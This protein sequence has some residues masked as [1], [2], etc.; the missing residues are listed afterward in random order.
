[1]INEDS[2]SVHSQEEPAQAD[3]SGSEIEDGT[4]NNRY[5]EVDNTSKEVSLIFERNAAKKQQKTLEG[6]KKRH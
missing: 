2:S 3:C 6:S 4:A 5:F 1:M